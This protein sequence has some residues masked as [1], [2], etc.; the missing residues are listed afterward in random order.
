[1]SE[2]YS[3]ISDKLEIFQYSQLSQ[4]SDTLVDILSL[5]SDLFKNQKSLPG[6]LSSTVATRV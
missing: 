4:D 5:Y 1:M 2:G 3:P 6:F